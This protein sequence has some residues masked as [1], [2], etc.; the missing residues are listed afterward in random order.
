MSSP[1]LLFISPTIPALS[2]NGLAMR[3]GMMLEAL[4]ADYDVYLLV[5][6]V[7]GVGEPTEADIHPS[8]ASWCARLA[9]HHV[10]DQVDALFRLIARVKDPRERLT[11]Y[12][13][14]PKPALC[15]FATT[16]AIRGA[17]SVFPGIR[18]REVHVFRLY[19]APFA[20][21]YLGE[22]SEDR[23][24][25]R[26]D[27]DD[28]ESRT[29]QR[30]ATL[31]ETAGDRESAAIERSET[32]KYA[33]MEQQYLPRFARTYVCSE[34]DRLAI[35]RQCRSVNVAVIPN[36]IRIPHTQAARASNRPFTFLF[37]GSLG[38]FPNA[39]AMRFFC[40]EVLPHL[41]AMAGRPFCI[42]IVGTHPS[43]RLLA[44]SAHHEVTVTGGVPD[45]AV[46]YGD[47]DAII[48]PLR[49]GGGTRIKL[50][51]AFSYR[52]AVV[53]TTL[54][55]EGID[56]RHGTHL[57]IADTAADFARQCVRL[58]QTPVLEQELV[59]RAFDFVGVNH[60][61]ER[62]RELLRREHSSA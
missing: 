26:L 62:I 52:R 47:A 9:I 35:A 39:D 16:N 10:Q 20:G 6:P 40:S 38:Y 51:E 15:R 33:V 55:A 30:L 8:V 61:L 54:G 37:V 21:P 34:H 44:L 14:Y 57:L 59:E 23:P 18:F 25:Y 41:R 60:S 22:D 43:P 2:G 1:P 58:M 4:A 49:A 50:L 7:V 45:V 27:L 5:I 11:A 13:A 48:I 3:A 17:A 31:H 32:T 28:Y 12:L 36:G 42:R 56:V 24:T 29:R 46:H 19:M 53:L